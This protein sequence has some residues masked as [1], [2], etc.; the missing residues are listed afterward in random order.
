MKNH[1]Y[2][3]SINHYTLDNINKFIE[4]MCTYLEDNHF[5][6]EAPIQDDSFGGFICSTN[7]LK[8]MFISRR[9]T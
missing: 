4:G 8:F 6:I 5:L 3:L 7:T 2:S 1:E 9:N